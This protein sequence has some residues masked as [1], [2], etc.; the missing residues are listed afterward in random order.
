MDSLAKTRNSIILAYQHRACEL[1]YEGTHSNEI[2]DILFREYEYRTSGSAIRHWFSKNGTLFEYYNE[3]AAEQND[4]RERVANDVFKA[5]VDKAQGTLARVMAGQRGMGVPQVLAAK[6]WLDRGL[7]KV[8]DKV[9]L[10]ARVGVYNF[11]DWAIKQAEGIKDA[12]ANAAAIT[13]EKISEGT[14]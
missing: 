9:K 2:A 11:A 12:E 13:A 3:Y 14:D 6:E 5:N 10:D 7:G 1:R 4:E 8:A